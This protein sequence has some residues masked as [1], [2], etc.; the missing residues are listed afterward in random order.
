MR[1]CQ[2]LET[3]TQDLRFGTRILRRNPVFALFSMLSLALGI[4]ATTAIFSLFD[5]I[6]LRTLPVHEPDRLVT[7]SFTLGAS[8]RPNRIMPY[9][10]FERM[11]DGNRTLD[12]MFAWSRIQRAMLT[13][14]GQ[15]E[16]VSG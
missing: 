10:Q 13:Y 1:T 8:N 3:A 7:L 12:S 16:M 11:R 9:P 6:V 5:A 4:G 2:W 15:S 14:D